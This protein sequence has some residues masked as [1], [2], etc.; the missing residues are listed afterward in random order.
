MLQSKVDCN[1][2]YFRRLLIWTLPDLNR[3]PPACE[4]GAL[5]TE[6][7]AQYTFSIPQNASRASLVWS[8]M[9]T[10][11]MILIA[12]NFMHSSF[13]LCFLVADKLEVLHFAAEDLTIQP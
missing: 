10:S 3:R 4:A 12:T 11:T 8:S 7:R 2:P 6:L 13:V 9:A 5:P 1:A